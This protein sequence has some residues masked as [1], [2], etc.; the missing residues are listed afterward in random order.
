MNTT[1]S[2]QSGLK[3][4]KWGWALLALV[5]LGFASLCLVLTLLIVRT[6]PGGGAVYGEPQIVYVTVVPTARPENPA[7]KA[8]ARP[9]LAPPTT[10]PQVIGPFGCDG[11]D[12]MAVADWTET[13]GFL[14][15]QTSDLATSV[16]E[17]SYYDW[18]GWYEEADD[19][20]QAMRAN[21]Y[22]MP[23]CF[24]DD[25]ET[26]QTYME[27]SLRDF[28]DA[29]GLLGDGEI[30]AGMAKLESA[31]RWTLLVAPEF[32]RFTTILETWNLGL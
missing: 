31:T 16:G 10:M 26:V 11:D 5:I 3:I 21:R 19:L 18:D 20:Y 24:R 6:D 14:Y 8:T 27:N 25:G 9:T 4:P 2:G 23:A 17:A 1:P 12:L 30:D 22:A 32:D 15:S 7:P 28:R 29:F 13:T